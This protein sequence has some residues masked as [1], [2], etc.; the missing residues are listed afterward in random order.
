MEKSIISMI[1]QTKEFSRELT[2]K[3][4]KEIARRLKEVLANDKS[5]TK[6]LSE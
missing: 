6:A 5:H 3:S 4:E 2:K 1:A